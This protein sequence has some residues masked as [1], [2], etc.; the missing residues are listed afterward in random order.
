MSIWGSVPPLMSFKL[1]SYMCMVQE[2]STALGFH[3]TPQMALSLICPSHTLTL[4]L[5]YILTQ[6]QQE[7]NWLTGRYPEHIKTQSPPLQ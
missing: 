4:P 2:V 3:M 5:E 1:P 6:R 7:V